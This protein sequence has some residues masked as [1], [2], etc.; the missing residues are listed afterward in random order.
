MQVPPAPSWKIVFLL[1]GTYNAA[2]RDYVG[3]LI[4]AALFF[5]AIAWPRLMRRGTAV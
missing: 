2:S 1:A 3:A 5:L 4:C